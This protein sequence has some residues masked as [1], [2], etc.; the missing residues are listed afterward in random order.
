M[1][2]QNSDI[3]FFTFLDGNNSILN[4]LVDLIFSNYNEAQRKN[5]D[6]GIEAEP[7]DTFQYMQTAL[8]RAFLI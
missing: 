6:N 7:L 1:I 2:S 8:V 5:F 4:S 3:F